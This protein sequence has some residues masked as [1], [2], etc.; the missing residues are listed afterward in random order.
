MFESP[1]DALDIARP[2]IVL[3]IKFGITCHLE[4]VGLEV[5]VVKDTEN[6]LEAKPDDVVEKN[7]EAFLYIFTGRQLVTKE[8]LEV[9]SLI[10]NL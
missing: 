3:E 8:G 10:S 6:V 4:G 7:N 9:L 5:M 2:D 1:G